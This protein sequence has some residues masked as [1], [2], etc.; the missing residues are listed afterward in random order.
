MNLSNRF[1]RTA[2]AAV[3]ATLLPLAMTGCQS[4]M[5]GQTLP[6]P[7]YLRD[8]VQFFPAGPEFLLPNQVR[9]LDEYKLRQSAIEAGIDPDA[10][11]GN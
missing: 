10:G 9:A 7:Y 8:D 5:A 4:Q 11:L 3:A 2:L 6:S 1:S